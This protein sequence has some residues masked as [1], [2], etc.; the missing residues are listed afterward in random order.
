[1]QSTKE[2][3]KLTSPLLIS[4]CIG[5]IS[6]ATSLIWAYRQKSYLLAFLPF[7]T[8]IIVTAFSDENFL[9]GQISAGIIGFFIAYQNKINADI[10]NKITKSR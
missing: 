1:M 10:K 4:L 6:P 8:A 5:F 7:L 9:L 3:R 2:R